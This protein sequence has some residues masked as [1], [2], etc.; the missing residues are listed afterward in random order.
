M[1]SAAGDTRPTH[2]PEG[3]EMSAGYKLKPQVWSW[4]SMGDRG[5]QALGSLRSDLY[6][7]GPA[8][9]PKNRAPA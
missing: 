1:L 6:Q 9:S 2:P 4:L 3:E 7:E 8:T 5:S